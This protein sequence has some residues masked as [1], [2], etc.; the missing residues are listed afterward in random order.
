MPSIYWLDEARDAFEQLSPSVQREI[1]RRLN[2]VRQFPELY[3]E[4]E[5]GRYRG[6]RRFPV[7][8]R[9]LVYYRVL[10]GSRNCIVGAIRPARAQ[11]E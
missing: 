4:T 5:M 11:P 1:N 2:L 6:Y 3:P 7:L 10:P 8:R 9:F